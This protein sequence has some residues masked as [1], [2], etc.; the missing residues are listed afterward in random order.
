V[1]NYGLLVEYY[2]C[3][4]C[5]CCERACQQEHEYPTGKSGVKVT[6]LY[7]E[8]QKKKQRSVDNMA[9]FTDACDLCAKRTG[10]GEE[11]VCVKRCPSR[12]I[13]YGRISELAT[14]M[15]REPR[16]ALFRPA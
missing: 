16:T 9:T 15:E 8:G 3:V 6:D 11:P 10:V 7:P 12:C 14:Q 4:G 5:R 1:S 13:K 2:F